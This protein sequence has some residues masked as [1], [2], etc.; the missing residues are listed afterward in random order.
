M[1]ETTN[2]LSDITDESLQKMLGRAL[3]NT[4]LLGIVPALILWAVSGWR[5][6]AMLAVG[7]LISAASIW[8]WQRLARLIAA[9][10]DKKKTAPGAGVQ[11]L[12]FVLRLTVFAGAIY[13]TLKCFQGS[14]LALLCGL[15]LAVTTM[16]WEGIRLLRD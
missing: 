1:T 14:P 8:E 10:M 15:G 16:A 4:L 2:P 13:V 12:F 9:R 11:V 5:N 6:A 7:T 3:R